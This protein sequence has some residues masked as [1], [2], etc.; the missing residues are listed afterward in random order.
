MTKKTKMILGCA[1]TM[2]IG[3]M[4]LLGNSYL[5]PKVMAA[6]ENLN[7]Q[8]I[9]AD[10]APILSTEESVMVVNDPNGQ[11]ILDKQ[12]NA[13][14]HLKRLKESITAKPVFIEGTPSKNDL[15]KDEAVKIAKKAVVE[16][17]ALTDETLSRF[18]I[19][20]S[21]NVV[22][23]DKP[24]WGITLNPTNQNDYPEIG[25]YHIIIKSP[26]GEVVKILSAADGVG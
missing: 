10:R 15:A 8:V 14:I 3:A 24:E 17:Y 16:K 26:S 5:M 12:R 6:D 2:A 4:A 19:L 20:T 22:N 7:Q 9:S 23:P 13:E 25:T 18:S 11:I 21:F 1:M